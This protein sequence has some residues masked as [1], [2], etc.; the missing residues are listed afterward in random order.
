MPAEQKKPEAVRLEAA[1]WFKAEAGAAQ[2]STEAQW[3][4]VAAGPTGT[5]LRRWAPGLDTQ[6]RE[7]ADQPVVPSATP[8]RGVAAAQAAR[9]ELP[10]AGPGGTGTR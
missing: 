8:S 6:A 2:I 10:G 5:R 4:R 7:V 3:Q 9:L 1:K